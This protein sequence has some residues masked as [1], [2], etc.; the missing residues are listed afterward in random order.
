MKTDE[1]ATIDVFAHGPGRFTISGAQE[2]ETDLLLGA[3]KAGFHWVR[4]GQDGRLEHAPAYEQLPA[5]EQ[6]MEMHPFW[7]PAGNPASVQMEMVSLGDSVE[8]YH[9]HSSPSIII[10]HLC[11]FHYTP[12][13]YKDQANFLTESGF[14]CMRSQRDMKS[15]QFW[16]LWFLPGLWM[17]QGRLREALFDSGKRNEKLRAKVA[18]EFL[19]RNSQFGTLD[20]AVQ[21]LAMVMSD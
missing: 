21:R 3:F 17:A 7:Q 1:I 9:R 12:Q 11:G 6:D 18:V 10:Q 13:N 4:R 16:E 8:A 2:E 19:K 15:G 14:V 5:P 20:I